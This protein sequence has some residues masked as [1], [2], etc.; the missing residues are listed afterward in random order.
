VVVEDTV[1]DRSGT[2]DSVAVIKNKSLLW[3]AD[4]ATNYKLQKP[5]TEGIDT[6]PAINVIQLINAANDSIRLEFVKTS[7]DTVFVHIPESHGLTEQIGS[8]GAE[9]YL[10]STTYSLTGVK[11]VRYVNYDFVEG[12]HAA[13]GVYSRDNFKQFR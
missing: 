6:M 1:Y 2:E 8:T 9:M 13:P 10:A 5:A 12:D 3:R 4:E 11:G 7:H